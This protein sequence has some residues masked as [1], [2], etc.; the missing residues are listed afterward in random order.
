M[1]SINDGFSSYLVSHTHVMYFISIFNLIGFDRTFFLFCFPLRLTVLPYY[2]RTIITA[3][4]Q[5][6]MPFFIFC[7]QRSKTPLTRS[8]S[9]NSDDNYVPMNPGSSP[10]S[11]AQADSPKNIYIPMSPGP[12][13]FDFPGFSATLP[14]RKGSCASLCHRPSRL[15][16]VTPPPINRNLKPNRKCEFLTTKFSVLYSKYFFLSVLFYSCL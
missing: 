5:T 12:H 9:G 7:H 4:L 2:F 16:D 13:H 14:T 8:D 3:S 11:V 6:I 10:L 15:S 1:E